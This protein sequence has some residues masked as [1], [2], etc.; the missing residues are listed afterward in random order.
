MEY[1]HKKSGNQPQN[2]NLL[3]QF[4]E[5]YENLCIERRRLEEE[6]QIEVLAKSSIIGMT[7]TGK[8]F[9]FLSYLLLLKKV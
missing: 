8:I 6:L 7:T 1:Y 4:C 2:D 5:Q 3:T 9:S